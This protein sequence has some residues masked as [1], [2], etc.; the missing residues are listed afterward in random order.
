MFIQTQE[1]P[2]PNCLK[3]LPGKDVL[4]SGTKDFPSAQAAYCSPLARYTAELLIRG[5]IEDILRKF[6]LFLNK[7]ICC[8]P[9]LE[10]SQQDCSN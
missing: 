7:N 4:E 8:D 6:F 5:D 2:N 10:L 3:F 9:S 1:T